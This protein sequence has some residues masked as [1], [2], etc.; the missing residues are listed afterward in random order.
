M[1]GEGGPPLSELKAA[2][3][4]F[5][6][7]EERVDLKEF[8]GVIDQLEGEFSV[9]AREA[10]RSGDHR[11]AGNISAASFI[12][13]ICGMSVP[14]AKD[15]LCVGEQLESLPMVAEALSKGE[16]SYQSAS[17][18]C[19]QRE[20]LGEKSDCLDEEQWL[21]FA[22]K[23]TIKDLNW[24]ADH[25]RYAVDPD[26]FDRD[27]EE[28]Y[29]ERFLHIS[30]MNGKYHLSG[31][32]DREAGVALKTA[33]DGL[34]KRLGQ[35]DRRTPKQRRADAL[36]EVVYK[37]MDEGKLPKRNGVRPH[38]TITTTLEGLKGE[39]RAAASELEAGMPISSKT[40][41]RFA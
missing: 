29:E 37:A 39:L 34:A 21:G 18:I 11:I 24:I 10:K 41:Q 17:V 15:R 3:R 23:H 9:E 26:G 27:T 36:T 19:H 14:S 1:S 13:Q 20:N 7:R 40:V 2:V 22:R 28:N 30:E 32:L 8:R 6:A 5:R 33:I 25:F 31:V 4:K 16:I 38:I 12:S 35:D